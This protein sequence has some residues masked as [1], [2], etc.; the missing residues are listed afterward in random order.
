MTWRAIARSCIGTSHKKRQ[1]P[2]QDYGQYTVVGD[3]IVG[4]VSDGAGSAKHA[5]EGA[6]LAVKTALSRIEQWL[7]GQPP[8]PI[9]SEQQAR[10]L[11][12]RMLET[13]INTL[14]TAADNSG[15]SLND[16]ACT[17]LVFI[18]APD[19][20]AAVQVGDGFILIGP[21]AEDYQLLFQPSKGEFINETTFV[22]TS[23][24]LNEMQVCVRPGNQEFICAATD[25]LE[26]VAIHI[27]DW[28]PFTPFF[29]PLADYMRTTSDPESE[30]EYVLDF[31]GSD[32]LNLRTDDDKTL[33]LCLYDSPKHD[34]NSQVNHENSDLC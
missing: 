1:I 7:S 19:W 23:N 11:F 27:R 12:S 16:L 8:Q 21:P 18:A 4:A 17:L 22:T 15:Y 2:C 13:V 10:E 6:K 14:Q 5:D 25:G 32:R 28:V 3:V 9:V 30:D 20:I 24:A 33:L 29:Q 34:P 26:K 31:L